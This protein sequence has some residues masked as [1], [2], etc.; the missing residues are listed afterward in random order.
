MDNQSGSA[1]VCAALH[2]L[3]FSTRWIDPVLCCLNAGGADRVTLAPFQ[4]LRGTAWLATKTA[5]YSH[6]WQDAICR[7]RP[8]M[9]PNGARADWTW[10]YWVCSPRQPLWES[11]ISPSRWRALP[12]KLKTSFDPILGPV[13]T[14]NLEAGNLKAIAGPGQ[15]GWILDHC[16]SSRDC[17]RTCHSG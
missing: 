1:L 16:R 6:I 10:P 15:S 17:A 5:Q 11:T 7:L 4:K 8:P 14:R 12:Q 2:A 3:L 13:I 9:L